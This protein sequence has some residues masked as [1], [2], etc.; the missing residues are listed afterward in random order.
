[1]NTDGPIT[2]TTKK[3]DER[4]PESKNRTVLFLILLICAASLLTLFVFGTIFFTRAIHST[5]P[6]PEQL[7]ISCQ[8]RV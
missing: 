1:M 4:S 8:F 7:S 5:L 2:F 6:K 3:S